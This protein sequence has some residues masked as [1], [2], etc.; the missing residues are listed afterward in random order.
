MTVQ[1]ATCLPEIP[2]K[3]V[4]KYCEPNDRKAWMGIAIT[5]FFQ[6]LAILLINFDFSIVGWFLNS[7]VIVRMFVQFHDMA[8]FS[9]FKSISLNKAIGSL[10]GVH[11]H[12]PF[13]A[14]R[15]GHNHHHKHFGNLDR[16]DLS[17]TILFTKKQYEKM[18]AG[19]KIIVRIFREPVV[20][21][22]ITAPFIWFFGTIVLTAKRYGV[23]SKPFF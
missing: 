19:K 10:L 8:H 4:L 15:D 6:A 18:P 14:W 22:L 20:F 9:Y 17:Q 21:F 11:V 2:K 23:L 1:E 7:L 13:Q 3:H 5:F 12:F 16:I